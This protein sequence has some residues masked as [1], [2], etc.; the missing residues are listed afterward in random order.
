MIM[1]SATIKL[2]CHAEMETASAK[3]AFSPADG[4]AFSSQFNV[5]KT[6]KQEG[7]DNQ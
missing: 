3:L 2:F 1:T 5:A 7:H 6:E 4:R